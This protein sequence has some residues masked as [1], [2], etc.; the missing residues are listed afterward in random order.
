MGNKA[1]DFK[2]MIRKL[3]LEKDISIA[4]LA[5]HPDVDL[6][7]GTLYNYLD[8]NGSDMKGENIAKLLDC[9]RSL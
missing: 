8:A 6:N 7:S 5:R 3:M 1:T 2:I 9:L 4:K